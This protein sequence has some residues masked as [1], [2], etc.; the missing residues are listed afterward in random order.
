MKEVILRSA[1]DAARGQIMDIY[2]SLDH[3]SPDFM[4]GYYAAIKQYSEL[5]QLAAPLHAK[6]P[7]EF[8]AG[9]N[10]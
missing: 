4:D 10:S 2:R 1:V 5:L 6:D 3:V 9:F 8:L 7:D